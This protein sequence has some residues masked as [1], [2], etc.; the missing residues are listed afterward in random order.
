[1]LSQFLIYTMAKRSRGAVEL[2]H[3]AEIA[4]I[5]SEHGS[6]CNV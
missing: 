6:Q 5:A 2:R 3:F 1:M 4:E